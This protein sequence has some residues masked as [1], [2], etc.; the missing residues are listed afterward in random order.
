MPVIDGRE[1]EIAGLLSALAA[2]A[3]SIDGLVEIDTSL[4]SFYV[5]A[6]VSQELDQARNEL[7]SEES[8]ES[9][10]MVAEE[11]SQAPVMAAPPTVEQVRE[12]LLRAQSKTDEDLEKGLRELFRLSLGR[13]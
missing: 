11:D 4:G 12:A 13:K 9:T 10:A 5:P 1:V 2:Q 3:R 7:V 6:C 8:V